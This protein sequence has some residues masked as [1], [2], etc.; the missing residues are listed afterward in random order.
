MFL[1]YYANTLDLLLHYNYCLAL[2]LL[3]L[4]LAYSTHVP[5]FYHSCHDKPLFSRV[6][7]NVAN[8]GELDFRRRLC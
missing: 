2:I 8:R 3:D 4:L 5:D 7:R 6:M 1:L